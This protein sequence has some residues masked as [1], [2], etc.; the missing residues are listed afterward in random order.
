M[1][2]IY[3]YIYIYVRCCL[4][5]GY[6]IMYPKT[7][8]TKHTSTRIRDYYSHRVEKINYY[9][10]VLVFCTNTVWLYHQSS[11]PLPPCPWVCREEYTRVWSRWHE[12]L[13]RVHL[14]GG[15]QN[16]CVNGLLINTHAHTHRHT[17]THTQHVCI[18]HPS[19]SLQVVENILEPTRTNESVLYSGRIINIL[20]CSAFSVENDFFN[21]RSAH[22]TRR[23]KRRR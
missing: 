22:V 12:R 11:P 15:Y 20:A 8:V 19:F 23:T 16:I 2:P 1:K 6:K 3:I 7:R 13:S 10:L 5:F 21:D 17:H 14:T 9:I 4:L 18:K